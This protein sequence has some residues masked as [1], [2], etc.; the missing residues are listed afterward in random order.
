MTRTVNK[1]NRIARKELIAK[2]EALGLTRPVLAKKL[3]LSRSYIFRVELGEIDP[4]F[5]KMTRWLA[6]LGEG[7]TPALFERH[8]NMKW[9]ALEP[10]E[11]A[12]TSAVLEHW[13]T[14]GVPGSLVAAIPNRRAFGQA[15]L[16]KGLPD[17]LVISPRLGPATGYI[18]L[19]RGRKLGRMSNE[20]KTIR[21]LLIERG[22]PYALT[23]GRDEPI[24]ILEAWGAVRPARAA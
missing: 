18:E 5:D 2:R 21:D 8:R 6:E 1:N 16:T 13:R 14:L 22:A 10:S 17:L 12:V 11:D 19:K 20:Q 24:K 7:A 15:G 4:D 23:R 3:G 9:A